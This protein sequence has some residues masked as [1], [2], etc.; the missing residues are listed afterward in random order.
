MKNSNS[1]TQSSSHQPPAQDS[2]KSVVLFENIHAKAQASLKE[3][4][5]DVFA[6]TKA[7]EGS[8]LIKKAESCSAVGIRSKTQLT[9]NLLRSLPHL[10]V[11]GAFCI[12]TNQIDLE[13]ANLLGIPVFNAPYANTRSVAELVM[14]EIIALTR[15]LFD[16][17]QMAHQGGW[18]KSAE[19]SHEV[20]GKTLGIVGYGHI[21]SQVSILA[22]AFGMKVIY[23]DVVKKLPLGNAQSALSLSEIL[24]NSDFVSLH[25]PETPATQNLMGPSQIQ[26]LK[27]GSFLINASRGTVVDIASLAEALKRGQVAGAAVDVFPVEP[28]SNQEKFVSPLQGLPNVILTPHIAGSTEEAQEAIGMEVSESLIRYFSRGDSIGAVNFPTLQVPDIGNY[29]RIF[30]VHKNVPGVLSS[31]NKIVTEEGGNIRAQH[32]ATDSNIGYL[33]IDIEG[34]NPEIMKEK[35]STLDS[36]LKTR[37]IRPSI[38]LS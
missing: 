35:I 12:G 11:I 32:L 33:V 8:E 10:H 34:G 38:A 4:G 17:S 6:Q 19:G 13:A 9:G 16:R 25:V 37:W 1:P 23:Y 29:P 36:S 30:N 26:E 5:F 27:K 31:I 21:G 28:A 18:D 7:F 22:E 14:S 15:R 20:R 24:R 2:L 3:N